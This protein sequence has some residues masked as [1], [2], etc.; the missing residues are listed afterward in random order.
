MISVV[1]NVAVKTRLILMKEI[2]ERVQQ[3][4]ETEERTT[5]Q[6][7]EAAPEDLRQFLT[8]DLVIRD[9]ITFGHSSRK[10]RLFPDPDYGFKG[11]KDTKKKFVALRKAWGYSINV[12]FSEEVGRIQVSLNVKLV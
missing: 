5:K 10:I 2:A 4:R 12:S 1:L 6:L 3:C 9:L 7:L 11:M 8:E